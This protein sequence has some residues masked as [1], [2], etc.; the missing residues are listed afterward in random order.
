MATAAGTI[1]ADPTLSAAD[2]QERIAAAKAAVMGVLGG[3]TDNHGVPYSLTEEFTSVYRM[4]PLLP[5][6]I[7]IT[8]ASTNKTMATFTL[9]DARM[10]AVKVGQIK[11]PAS[12]AASAQS[13]WWVTISPFITKDDFER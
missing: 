9:Q 2:K 4:H 11:P 12:N 8:N 3:D 7:A 6:T 10:A 5:D 13:S 1:L